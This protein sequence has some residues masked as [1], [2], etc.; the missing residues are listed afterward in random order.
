MCAARRQSDGGTTQPPRVSSSTERDV[1]EIAADRQ[2]PVGTCADIALHQVF[3]RA[4]APHAERRRSDLAVARLGQR[5]RPGR[6]EQRV[7]LEVVVDHARQLEPERGGALRVGRGRR[8][9]VGGEGGDGDLEVLPG[10]LVRHG[11]RTDLRRQRTAGAGTEA[12]G[13]APAHS[14][15]AAV[16]RRTAGKAELQVGKSL[17]KVPVEVPGQTLPLVVELRRETE[18]RRKLDRA[19]GLLDMHG[20][21]RRFVAR[22]D[23]VLAD[24]QAGSPFRLPSGLSPEARRR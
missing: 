21:L 6:L 9:A 19:N 17:G 8:L 7:V 11:D 14:G 12:P 5:I 20:L 2:P 15:K 24:D 18:W 13:A 22:C 10:A 16:A 1:V 3:G 4:P 23:A